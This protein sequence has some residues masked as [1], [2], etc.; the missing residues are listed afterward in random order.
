M[1]TTTVELL[2]KYKD[3]D[4]AINRVSEAEID[5]TLDAH[6][7]RVRAAMSELYNA[8]LLLDRSSRETRGG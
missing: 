3:L 4:R 6:F 8:L 7:L 1:Q 5:A 2:H